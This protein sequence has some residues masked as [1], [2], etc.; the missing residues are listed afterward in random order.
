MRTSGCGLADGEKKLGKT[1]AVFPFPAPGGN[2]DAVDD[3]LAIAFRAS[4][5]VS[6]TAGLQRHGSGRGL[7]A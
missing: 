6:E 2:F 7:W 5:F 3:D 1:A 4:F